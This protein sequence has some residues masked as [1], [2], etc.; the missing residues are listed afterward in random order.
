MLFLYILR[1]Y[2]FYLRI[3]FYFRDKKRKI[4][5]YKNKKEIN[6]ILHNYY[7]VSNEEASTS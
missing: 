5:K 4:K 1:R 2:L 6:V 3:L 7:N